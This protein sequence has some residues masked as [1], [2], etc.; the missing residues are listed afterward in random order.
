MNE[1]CGKNYVQAV[2]NTYQESLYAQ[3]LNANQLGE[4]IHSKHGVTQGKKSPANF[5]SSY[6]S[7]MGKALENVDTIEFLG[8]YNQVQFADDTMLM[9]EYFESLK[10]K[11]DALFEYSR[12]KYQLANFKKTVFAHFAQHPKILPRI[13]NCEAIK[14]IDPDEGHSYLGILFLPTN[15]LKKI[16][17][18]NINNR[19]KHIAKFYSW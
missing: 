8:P 9:A 16:L 15:D 13:E 11:F 1:G 7:D 3:K 5:V 14:S 2:A 19:L 6:M 10:R 17:L 12:K 18:L 4:C